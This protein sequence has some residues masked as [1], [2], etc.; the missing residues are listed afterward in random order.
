MMGIAVDGKLIIDEEPSFQ[1][2]T[3]AASDSGG[4]IFRKTPRTVPSSLETDVFTV[5]NRFP[6]P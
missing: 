2:S 1:A 4:H 6:L 3:T 5:R